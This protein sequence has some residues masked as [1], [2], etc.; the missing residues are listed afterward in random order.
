[1]DRKRITITIKKDILNKIDKKIDGTRIRNRSH[2]IEYILSKSFKTKVSQAVILAGGEGAKMRPLTY[3]L[4]KP[5]IPVKGK[6]ILEYIIENLRKADIRDI[7]LATGHLGDKIRQHFGKG[8]KFGVNISYSQEKKNLGTAGALANCY[9]LIKQQ[10]F[11]VLHGDVL[12][13]IDIKELIAFHE[14]QSNKTATLVLSTI[15]DPTSY[16]NVSLE[17]NKIIKFTEKPSY[18]QTE[19]YLVSV[20]T[21][22]FEHTIFDYIPE[23]LP[24]MLENIFPVLAKKGLLRGFTF[25][26]KWFDISTPENYEKAISEWT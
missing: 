25:A 14:S 18:K 12:I 8:A 3:E 17:G 16:G 4:P 26:G 9:K 24:A 23:K 1:M 20:G 19:S 15:S 22:V 7:I 6:P 11:L 5:L 2:A 10:P 21:Y 13:E